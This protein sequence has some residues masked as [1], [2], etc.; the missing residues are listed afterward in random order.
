M[1][2]KGRPDI[3]LAVNTPLSSTGESG[4]FSNYGMMKPSTTEF[5]NQVK[6]VIDKGIPVSMVDVYFANGSDNTLMSLMK[7]H[8]LL[9]PPTMDGTRPP[10]RSA[11][12]S[13]RPSS[14]R[15]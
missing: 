9:S 11:M 4:Q 7:Q 5:M 13:L 14:R 1:D 2:P 6:A 15:T 3:V 10:T 8:D 12:P